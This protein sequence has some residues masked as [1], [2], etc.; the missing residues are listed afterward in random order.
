MV[1]V[2]TIISLLLLPTGFGGVN[3]RGI[4]FESLQD[5]CLY[6]R[7]GEKLKGLPNGRPFFMFSVIA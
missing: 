3:S 2:A 1:P 6:L 4:W 5:H 7:E